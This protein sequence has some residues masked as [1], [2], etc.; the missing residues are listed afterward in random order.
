MC[1]IISNEETE[2]LNGLPKHKHNTVK[3]VFDPESV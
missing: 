1:I 3:L 2:R